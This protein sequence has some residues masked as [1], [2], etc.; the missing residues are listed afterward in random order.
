MTKYTSM[1]L[2]AKERE[3]EREREREWDAKYTSMD[4]FFYCPTWPVAA[5]GCH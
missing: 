1:N 5:C 4:L 2:L 3:R